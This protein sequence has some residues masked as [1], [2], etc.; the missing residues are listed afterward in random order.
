M[1]QPRLSRRES[2]ELTRKRLIDGAIALLR[3][4]GVA[5][6]TTGR[7]AEAAGIA[8]SSFYGH[9]S[10]RD[11]CLEAAAAQIGGYVLHKI[12]EQQADVTP[13]DLRA[14]IERIYASVLD[15]FLAAPAL[16]RIFL[17]HRDDDSSALGRAFRALIDR[18]RA[19]LQASFTR[20]GLSAPLARAT[21]IP[22]YADLLIG[23]TLAGVENLLSQRGS[24]ATVLTAL[25]DSTYAT[26][27]LVVARKANQ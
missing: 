17:R 11:E 12:R 20:Y 1:G 3:R 16:T 13:T 18:A 7:I 24:R 14:S 10:D 19:D 22:I 6:A 23:A 27:T 2:K 15:A 5:A 8:Q 9:F 4:E 25:T 21:D 26:L